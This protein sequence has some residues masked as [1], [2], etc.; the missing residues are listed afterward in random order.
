MLGELC[1]ANAL[2]LEKELSLLGGRKPMN[3]RGEDSRTYIDTPSRST[4]QGDEGLRP[5]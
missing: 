1:L 3:Q 4:H 5:R 2:W